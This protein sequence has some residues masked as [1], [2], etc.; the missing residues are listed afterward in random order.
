[1]PQVRRFA[2]EFVRDV[3]TVHSAA[4]RRSQIDKK[5][6]NIHPPEIA[7]KPVFSY[8]LITRSG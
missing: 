4:T 7:I 6:L 1:M 5:H 3:L 2:G 8:L